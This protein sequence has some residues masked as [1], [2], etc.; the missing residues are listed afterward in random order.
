MRCESHDDDGALVALEVEPTSDADRALAADAGLVLTREVVQMR[1]AL[2]LGVPTPELAARPFRPGSDDAAFLHCNNRA[3]EWHPDQAGWTVDDLRA[4]CAEPWFDAEGFLVHEVDGRID[5]F[6]WTKV[7]PATADD[8]ALGEIFVIGVDPDRHGRGLGRALV[9]A[10]LEHL[11]AVGLH[12][13]MLHVERGNLPA[14]RLYDDL[15]FVDH[16]SHCW[17]ARPAD[18]PP[19]EEGP[20]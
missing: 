17:F 11:G 13:G 19:N 20:S 2:P 7:H 9:V 4:R 16:S 1:V 18:A 8:P 5:G 3:F 12:V 6:C 14:R 10:G 15:G